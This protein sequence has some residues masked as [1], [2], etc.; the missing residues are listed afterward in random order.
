MCGVRVRVHVRV[1]EGCGEQLEAGGEIM[2]N[3]G[4]AGREGKKEGLWLPDPGVRAL[5]KTLSLV[6][7]PPPRRGGH[8]E[9]Q[10]K[11]RQGQNPCCWVAEEE[12]L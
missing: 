5:Q 4:Q 6:I 3:K 8:R 10:T 1:G 9:P 2:Q 7:P 12:K 11:A